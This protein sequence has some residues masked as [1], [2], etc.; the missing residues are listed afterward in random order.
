MVVT[1]RP[2]LRWNTWSGVRGS[3]VLDPCHVPIHMGVC[4]SDLVVHP[5]IHYR[6]A[7]LRPGCGDSRPSRPS[8]P[9]RPNR[10]FQMSHSPEMLH[11]TLQR[12]TPDSEVSIHSFLAVFHD[13]TLG[14][15]DS[16]WFI[17]NAALSK[18][19]QLWIYKLRAVCSSGG[20]ASGLSGL[21]QACHS[22]L[23]FIGRSS[24]LP[25]HSLCW[26]PDMLLMVEHRTPV[27]V[28]E[29]LMKYH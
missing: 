21:S 11:F 2:S 25:A 27:Q 18:W 8:R 29:L 17:D 6:Y 24:L 14:D 10:V 16:Q 7:Y 23:S 19:I 15:T 28:I 26:M 22:Q 1:T 4:F 13:L 9:N 3:N 20:G 12:L 5:S